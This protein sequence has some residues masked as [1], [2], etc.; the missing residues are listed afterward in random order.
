MLN[1]YKYPVILSLPHLCF[2]ITA[3]VVTNHK[4]LSPIGWS[5]KE[6]TMSFLSLFIIA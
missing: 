3:F 2:F 1:I 6:G 4:D 5:I